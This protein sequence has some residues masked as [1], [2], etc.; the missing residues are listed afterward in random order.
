MRQKVNMQTATA[1]PV[2]C[3]VKTKIQASDFHQKRGLNWG[4]LRRFRRQI[5]RKF[6]EK[7]RGF[8]QGQKIIVIIT[9]LRDEKSPKFSNNH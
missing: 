2:I 3:E 5:R 7:I 6:V 8:S 9:I 1:V 4:F